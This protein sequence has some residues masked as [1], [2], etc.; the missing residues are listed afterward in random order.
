MP[1]VKC[2]YH[3]CTSRGGAGANVRSHILQI[4][5]FFMQ[6]MLWNSGHRDKYFQQ[7]YGNDVIDENDLF[8]EPVHLLNSF[9]LKYT[10]SKVLSVDLLCASI[11]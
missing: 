1:K 10:S 7:K 9:N 4:C 8:V 11:K 5:H 6:N 2:V 3:R